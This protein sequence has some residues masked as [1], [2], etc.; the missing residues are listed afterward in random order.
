MQKTRQVQKIDNETSQV[1]QG[2]FSVSSSHTLVHGVG[3]IRNTLLPILK[4]DFGINN[5]QVGILS[6]VPPLLQA[7][8]SLPAGWISDRYGSKKVVFG[9][10]LL[11]FAGSLLAAFSSNPW[12]Y[13]IAAI[14]MTVSS[15]VFHPPAFCFIADATRPDNRSKYMGLFNAG[16]T[17]GMSLGPLSITLVVG[18]LAL[19]WNQLYLIWALPIGLGLFYLLSIGLEDKPKADIISSSNV[20]VSEQNNGFLNREFLM[21]IT[22]RGIRMLGAGMFAP[23]LSI[24][25]LEVQGW[26]IV[27]I[28]LMMGISGVLGL[29]FAPI[30][31]IYASKFG[32]KRFV[33]ISTILSAISFMAAF[34]TN[35]IIPFMLFYLG[36]RVFFIMAMPGQATITARLSPPKQ[37]GMGFALTFLPSSVTGVISPVIAAWIID[38]FGYLPLFNLCTVTMLIATV[39]FS[40]GIQSE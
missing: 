32:E 38:L 29:F 20:D 39:I 10:L 25:L 11:L 13:V 31:G 37:I 1:N 26:P 3:N 12:T 33:V 17:L 19:H 23:F 40:V 6:A 22:S 34:Y 4:E 28:G 9:S 24:Y 36:Y 8:F 18:M 35:G 27:Q 21:Y 2:L 7:I 16:G 30:G 5:Y 14:M 15:T